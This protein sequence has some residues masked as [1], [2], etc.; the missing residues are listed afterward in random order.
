MLAHLGPT[1]MRVAIVHALAW[2]DRAPL[3][4]RRLD[5][6][7]LGQMTFE[8]PDRE[9]FPALDLARRAMVAGGAAPTIL[10][11][12]NEIAVAAFLERR[13]GFLDIASIV[14]A[15]LNRFEAET[16]SANSPSSLDEVMAT[17]ALGRLWAGQETER[18]RAA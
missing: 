1:D 18:R 8:T 10:N 7:D 15:V 13:I 12:A 11:A 9:R 2:P 16:R 14:E 3:A 4:V 17:D 5:L 6:A